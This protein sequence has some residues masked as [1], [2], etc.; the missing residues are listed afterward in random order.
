MLNDYFRDKA[1]RQCVERTSRALP[2]SAE[3][4][5]FLH[6]LSRLDQQYIRKNLSPGSCADLPTI[7]LMPFF[8]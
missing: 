3:E 8:P 7:G 6:T 4:P 5:N 1:A 2:E